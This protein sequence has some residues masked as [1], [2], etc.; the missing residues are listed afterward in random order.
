MQY[1]FFPFEIKDSWLCSFT[2]TIIIFFQEID[3]KRV[4][5]L[6]DNMRLKNK[7]IHQLLEDIEHLENDNEAYQAK[8]SNLRDELA[9]AT[10]QISMITS[11]YV[12]MKNGLDDTKNLIDTL[13]HD[14]SNIKLVLEDQYKEK[15][16]RDNQ[17]EEIS[18]QVGSSFIFEIAQPS[19]NP[20]LGVPYFQAGH[21]HHCHHPPPSCA[22]QVL[23]RQFN[24]IFAKQLKQLSE[25]T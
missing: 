25:L 14:N 4:K 1:I 17:I 18:L 16:K 15:S 6:E 22:S 20:S 3:I 10:R 23:D 13:R 7:Q 12:S 19:P 11:E 21:H 8:I 5:D 2:I 24:A 9:E